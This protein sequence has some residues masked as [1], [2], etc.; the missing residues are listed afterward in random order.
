MENFEYV[1]PIGEIETDNEQA[2]INELENRILQLNNQITIAPAVKGIIGGSVAAYFLTRSQDQTTKLISLITGGYAG[3]MLFKNKHLPADKKNEIETQINV[4]K[5][6]LARLTQSQAIN[7]NSLIN[8]ETLLNNEYDVFNFSG[9][10]LELIGEPTKPFHTIVFGLPKS[11]KSIFCIQFAD[12]LGQNFGRVLYIA[13]E[14][15]FSPTLQKK[16]QDFVADS[17]NLDFAS[18]QTFDEIM[19]NDLSGYRFVFIDSLN[20][21]KITVDELEAI[22]QAYPN[23]SLITIL[24]STKNGNFRGSQEYAHNCD[25]IITIEN[26]IAS[27]KGRFQAASSIMV[28]DE[29]EINTG[30]DPDFQPFEFVG[31]MVN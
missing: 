8:S 13:A 2:Q 19:E 15:K 18:F 1:E 23:I 3:Y 14:E 24:Q 17:S 10:Y 5:N 20:F 27:Q 11:G 22:K 7:G 9:K 29:P 16:V 31:E 21:A 4:L 28:F 30:P 6:Q 12:Y 25:V 26:G